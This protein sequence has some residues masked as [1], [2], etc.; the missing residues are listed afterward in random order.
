MQLTIRDV[1]KL[2][3]I[4]ERTIYR[5]I[6][7]NSIP[8]Y[9]IHDQYRFN[10]SELLEWAAAN[11]VGVSPDIFK[12]PEPGPGDVI[13]IG[14]ALKAGGIHYRVEGDDR[15]SVLRSVV[16]IMKLPEDTDREFLLNILVSREEMGSTGIGEGIAIPHVR[17]PIVLN[18]SYCL[19]GLCF[20]EKPI[21]FGAIDGKPVHCLFTIISPTA[22]VHLKL[23]SKL[24]FALKDEAFKQAVLS[25]GARE[26]ILREITRIEGGIIAPEGSEKSTDKK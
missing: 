2:L 21:D 26:L 10:K 6:K 11:K 20:L 22:K 24:V 8:A 9:R 12:E 19:I 4:S 1:S 23:L 18:V 17:N 16:E 7:E 5:W 3:N 14:D 13:S 15:N 25:H